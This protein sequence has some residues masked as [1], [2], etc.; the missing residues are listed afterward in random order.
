MRI[1]SAAAS[2]RRGNA[3]GE[4]VLHYRVDSD[5]HLVRGLIVIAL[6][7]CSDHTVRGILSSD[8]QAFFRELGLEQ[9]LTPQRFNE[10]RAMIKCI[11]ADAAL[12]VGRFPQERFGKS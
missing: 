7:L 4:R 2:A 9:H 11:C 3:T 5:S 6:A 8:A 10:V 12:W 1:K